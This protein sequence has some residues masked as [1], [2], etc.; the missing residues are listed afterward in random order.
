MSAYI[1]GHILQATIV[2]SKNYHL[3]DT[4]NMFDKYMPLIYVLNKTN[5][6]T[7]DVNQSNL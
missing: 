2:W 5:N 6:C 1:P 3:P 4:H 7:E